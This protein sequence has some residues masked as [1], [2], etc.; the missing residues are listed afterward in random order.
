MVLF[1]GLHDWLPLGQLNNLAGI[2]AV[3][4]TARYRQRFADTYAFFSERNG[5]R[6]DTL[7]VA[8]HAVFIV[9]IGLLLSLLLAGRLKM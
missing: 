3:A 7:H 1:I 8:F 6:P 2:R 4:R 5:I 9:T